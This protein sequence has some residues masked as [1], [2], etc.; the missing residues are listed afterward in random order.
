MDKGNQSTW[1]NIVT[2]FEDF[3][4]VFG[5]FFMD[6]FKNVLSFLEFWSVMNNFRIVNFY[7]L[8]RKIVVKS[9]IA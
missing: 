9:E 2:G 3:I 1:V 5:I 6:G 7:F 8:F 4:E